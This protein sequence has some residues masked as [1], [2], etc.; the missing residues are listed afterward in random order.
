[1]SPRAVIASA[2]KW[3]KAF[4]VDYGERLGSTV[5]YAA[6]TLLTST[7]LDVSPEALWTLVGL[8]VVLMA[9]KGLLANMKDSQTGA[10]LVSGTPGPVLDDEAGAIDVVRALVIALL[11]VALIILLAWLL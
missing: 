6:L 2:S 1:M 3:G 5:L 7:Q 11:V 4:W 9:I 8:P 10:S